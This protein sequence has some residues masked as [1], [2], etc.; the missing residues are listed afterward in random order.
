[1]LV[2]KKPNSICKNTNCRKEF[3]ACAYC[4][5][6]MAWRS[7]ACSLECY[8]EYVNQV[9][10]ARARNKIVN[11]LPERTDMTVEEVQEL[12]NTSTEE[13]IEATREELK[14]YADDLMTLGLSGTIDK[15]NDEINEMNIDDNDNDN[16]N[17]SNG[18]LFLGKGNKKHH[19]KNKQL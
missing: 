8:A 2:I 5:H 14:D 16:E 6:T 1:M 15:I 9:E 17:E 7:V 19:R 18:S 10:I 3:Y 13:A 4:T 12:I 11:I